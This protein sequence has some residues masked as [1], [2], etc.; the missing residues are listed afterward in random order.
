[1]KDKDFLMI[2][3]PTPTPESVLLAL[4]K[5]PIGHRTPEF[6]EI[7]NDV[8]KGLQWLFQTNQEVI[9]LA[10][11]GTG[12]MEAAIYNTINKGDKIL[13]VITGKFGERWGD[14]ARMKGATVDTIDIEWG[15][16]LDVNVLKEKLDADKNKEYKA[17]CITHNETSTGVTNKLE[18]VA[19]V[20]KAHGALLIV[21]AIT[22]LGAID[23]PF[24]KWGIDIAVSGSQKGFMLPPGL[25]FI[26]LSD[27]AW[28][29]VESCEHPSFYFNLKSARK[30]LQKGTTPYTPA[31]NMFVALNVALE[32]MQKEGLQNIFNRHAAI[33]KCAQ[34]AATAIGLKLF[35][36]DPDVRSNAITA[37]CAPEG[38]DADDFRKVMKKRFDISLAG[39]QDHLKGKIFRMG[40]LGFCIPREILATIPCIE[41]CMAELGYDIEFGKGSAAAAKVLFELSKEKVSV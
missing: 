9:T 32:M 41:I 5:H 6:T 37:I 14:I 28:E 29:V 17:V 23:L 21:D 39:G 30:N 12:A 18:A 13:S 16:A 15:K 24:D 26:T 25:A 38:I 20:V 31:V 33:A 22:S 7:F 40:H 34:A 3:G 2:P 10:S 4:A 1:M 11:S 19:K 8:H 27:K 35:V 36:E